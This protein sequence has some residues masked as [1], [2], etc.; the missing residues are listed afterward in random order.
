MS[1][2]V[3]ASKFSASI[4]EAD[5]Y[6]GDPY[7]DVYE[8]SPAPPGTPNAPV[9]QVHLHGVTSLGRFVFRFKGTNT[10]DALIDALTKHREGVWGKR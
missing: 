3:V 2:P 5:Y 1:E 4:P 7:F 6:E 10:I 8:W 9:T